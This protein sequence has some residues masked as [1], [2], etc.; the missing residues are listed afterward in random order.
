[1]NSTSKA[2]QQNYFIAVNVEMAERALTV[3][4]QKDIEVIS[5][6]IGRYSSP[7]IKV[8]YSSRC[9]PLKGHG[10]SQSPI[11]RRHVNLT[12]TA[13][14]QCIVMWEEPIKQTITTCTPALAMH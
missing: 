11:S 8:R 9:E 1:M 13:L 4:M 10:Y 2:K 5:L 14:E 3:L 12:R 6:D 7:V